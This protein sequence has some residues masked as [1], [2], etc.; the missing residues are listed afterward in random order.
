MTIK[1][2]SNKRQYDY[3]RQP[4]L[5]LASCVLMSTGLVDINCNF[6]QRDMYPLASMICSAAEHMILL[7]ALQTVHVLTMLLL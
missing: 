2:S 3:S 5:V 4:L 1:A 7:L 6:R